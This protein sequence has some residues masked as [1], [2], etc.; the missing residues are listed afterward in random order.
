M[1]GAG[2]SEAVRCLQLSPVLWQAEIPGNAKSWPHTT[3]MTQHNSN[4]LVSKTVAEPCLLNSSSHIC[5]DASLS[6]SLLLSSASSLPLPLS[7]STRRRCC[8]FVLVDVAA[9]VVVVVV[10]VVV[11]AVRS[12]AACDASTMPWDDPTTQSHLHSLL[13]VYSWRVCLLWAFRCIEG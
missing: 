7:L 3:C 4:T 1:S 12:T 5:R 9:V 6:L 10:V 13:E 11:A 2:L 8:R